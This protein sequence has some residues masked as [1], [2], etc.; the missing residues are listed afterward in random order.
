MKLKISLIAALIFSV[1]FST[2]AFARGN[3][4][5]IINRTGMDIRALYISPVARD[6]WTRCAGSISRGDSEDIYVN[7]GSTKYFDIRCTYRNG[8][9]DIWYGVDLYN[10]STVTL[11]REGH[12][13]TNDSGSSHHRRHRGYDDDDDDDDANVRRY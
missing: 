13:R 1:L 2:A 3:E 4:V 8:D 10:S 6:Q 9:E 11:G 12:F 5:E 7:S